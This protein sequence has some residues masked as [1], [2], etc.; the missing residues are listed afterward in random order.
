MIGGEG[1]RGQMIEDG[2]GRVFLPW[3]SLVFIE[4]EGNSSSLR[5]E[6]EGD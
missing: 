2:A 1:T 5:G 3:L 6:F 4:P